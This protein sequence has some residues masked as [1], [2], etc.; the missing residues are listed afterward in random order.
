M[1]VVE[2][3]AKAALSVVL[4]APP[5]KAF[6]P[7]QQILLPFHQ[8]SLLRGFQNT[9]SSS[10]RAAQLPLRAV[11]TMCCICLSLYTECHILAASEREY[12]N[13]TQK[14]SSSHNCHCFF[15]STVWVILKKQTTTKKIIKGGDIGSL[16][17]MKKKHHFISVWGF[18]STPVCSHNPACKNIF[19]W[20]KGHWIIY[21]I[22][23]NAVNQGE[24]RKAGMALYIICLAF[25]NKLPPSNTISTCKRTTT[26]KKNRNTA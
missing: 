22:F 26:T 21:A 6:S 15:L 7:L 2:S 8:A 11:Q 1:L 20:Y 10:V 23:N 14:V 19:V 5:S 9:Q 18:C 24:F 12:F 16:E 17:G 13:I 25:A 3:T 4:P